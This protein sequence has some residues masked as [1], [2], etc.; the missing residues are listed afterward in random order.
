ML[1]R[2]R[3][4]Q[5]FLQNVYFVCVNFLEDPPKIP[6]KKIKFVASDIPGII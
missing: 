6:F 2:F 4:V 3:C 1:K 5:I